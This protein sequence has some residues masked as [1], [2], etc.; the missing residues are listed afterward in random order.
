MPF[1]P[2]NPPV[3]A[4]ARA[5]TSSGIFGDLSAVVSTPPG[6]YLSSQQKE[7]KGA[8]S[9]KVLYLLTTFPLLSETFV[10]REVR[11]LSRF[12]LELDIFSLWSG[13]PEFEGHR[14]NLFPKW[15]LLTLVWWLPF[16][17][18]RKPGALA[19]LIGN[20][21]QRKPASLTDF[22]ATMI[23]I[24]FAV[25]HARHF[26]KAGHR[27]ALIHAGW[28]TMPATAGQLLS[29]LI[30]VPFTFQANA[31][32]IFRDGGDWLLPGKLEDAGLVITAT[33]YARD[34]LITRGAPAAKVVTIRR[35]LSVLPP[36]GP[37]RS[38]RSPL[39]L[40]SVGRLVEKKGFRR[41]IEILA[42]LKAAG[43]RFQSR[44][45][46]GGPLEKDLRALV[47]ARNLEREVTLMGPQSYT[48]C[49]QQ[50]HWA[51]VFLF[52]GEVA[53]NGDRDG[54]PNV[55]CE[56]MA[57]GVPVV[58]TPVAGVPEAVRDGETGVIVADTDPAA[59][60][61]A[62][63]RLRDDGEFYGHIRDAACAWI[64]EN[65]DIDINARLLAYCFYSVARRNAAAWVQEYAPANGDRSVGESPG[66]PPRPV[67]R[68]L[69]TGERVT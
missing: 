31:F 37:S 49:R 56:A 6:A 34:A 2:N 27:P 58:A 57:C 12:P 69:E 16:W 47:K 4:R 18:V 35:G 7:S 66:R 67:K 15:K 40:L 64:R 33:D 28:A 26:S 54:L 10:K 22:A 3:D 21:F 45:I 52:T 68:K 1:P 65:F 53:A 48:V 46:G 41:Q 43:F 23:G 29:A 60:C 19:R 30:D 24:A 51:D 20:L 55:V 39:R 11:A 5:D 62:L 8:P 42:G 36:R 17:L 25:S 9:L 44:I 14:V 50:Y 38:L 32:D 13:Q 59:W 63:S 61:S